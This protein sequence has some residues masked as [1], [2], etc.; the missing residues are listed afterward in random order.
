MTYL[1]SFYR[2]IIIYTICFTVFQLI[3]SM[4]SY[5][6]DSPVLR[7]LHYLMYEIRV[8]KYCCLVQAQHTLTIMHD[9]DDIDDATGGRWSAERTD[10]NILASDKNFY[11]QA[12]VSLIHQPLTSHHS[13][14]TTS[15]FQISLHWTGGSRVTSLCSIS[16]LHLSEVE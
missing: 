2:I 1:T 15:C 8:Y 9:D 13:P 3:M 12:Q 11:Y 6:N 5:Q 10:D 4:M 7:M 14:L 16:Y